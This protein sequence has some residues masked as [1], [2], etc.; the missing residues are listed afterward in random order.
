MSNLRTAREHAALLRDLEQLCRK[1][2]ACPA[3]A[4]AADADL[5]DLRSVTAKLF[6]LPEQPRISFNGIPDN[7]ANADLTYLAGP[8]SG[9]PEHYWPAF[10]A[11]AARL[12]DAG[13]TVI[14]PA[15]LHPE[16]GS[17][18]LHPWDWYLRRD[19]T[20]LVKCARVVFLEGWTASDGARL[21]HK[22]AEGLGMTIIYP[23]DIDALI[24]NQ[25]RC[26]GCG[27][28][29]Q[30]GCQTGVCCR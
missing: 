8:M 10:N 20:E 3:V 30:A 12:R 18:G 25:F 23:P 24:A 16:P 9:Y 29:N 28:I 11:M 14:N 6:Q 22:V 2:T 17:T 15:E 4:P 1:Y 7:P 5:S 19:I 21:E 13:L 26:F 27:A